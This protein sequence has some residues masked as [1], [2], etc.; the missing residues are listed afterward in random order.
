M[1]ELS[2]KVV[3]YN[4]TTIMNQK[5]RLSMGIRKNKRNVSRRAYIY[6]QS[7]G[8]S[9]K[10]HEEINKLKCFLCRPIF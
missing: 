6:G 7:E 5:G 3:N 1:A 9:T 2:M 8:C 10:H 4:T